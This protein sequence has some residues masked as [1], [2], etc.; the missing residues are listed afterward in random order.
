MPAPETKAD[1]DPARTAVDINAAELNP[2][3]RPPD[4][5]VPP[6]VLLISPFPEDHA[7]L[8]SIFEAPY[9]RTYHA[10][11]YREALSLLARDRMTVVICECRLP[12]GDWKDVLGQVEVL[13]EPPCL[14]VA[15][16]LPDGRLWAEVLNLG[17]YDI[18]AKPFARKEVMCV[19]ELAAIN[20]SREAQRRL[21]RA[22][23]P[24]AAAAAGT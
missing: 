10:R 11:G 9:W 19:A 18:L 1:A 5:K 22:A 6:S 16:Q 17:G 21:S 2:Q 23:R 4:L 12:D 24:P 7:F 3:A 8:T 13:S 15:S 20:W 14:I